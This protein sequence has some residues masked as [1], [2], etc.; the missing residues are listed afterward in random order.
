MSEK[1]I[2][3]IKERYKIEKSVN[4]KSKIFAILNSL[5]DAVY[6]RGI[7]EDNNWDLNAVGEIYKK[8]D[9]YIVLK[10]IDDRLHLLGKYKKKPTNEQIEGLVK[11]QI[12]NPNNSRYGLNISK[13][14]DVF[15]IKKQIAGDDYLFGFY[16]NLEDA[17]FCRNFLLDNEWNVN[18]F[19]KVEFD[20][21]TSTYKSVNV[22][23]DK[24]C[25]LNTHKSEKEAIEG[26]DKSL[27]DFISKIYKNKHGLANYPHLDAF[28]DIEFDQNVVDENWDLNELSSKSAKDLIF[29]LS[30]WQ[31]I[32]YDS[33]GEVFTFDEVKMSLKRFKSRNFEKKIQKHL[34]ELMEL[35][36]IADRGNGAYKKLK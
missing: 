12:R 33:T 28:K 22:I 16:D 6:I 36:I 32:I 26:Y 30:P 35:G 9:N 8:D 14:F 23:D 27:N 25:V 2:Y 19:S 11:K 1:N 24:V 31:K 34:D 7:L 18:R 17:E 4:G 5:D 21:E 20:G 15:V 10:V 29:N 13:V 3:K